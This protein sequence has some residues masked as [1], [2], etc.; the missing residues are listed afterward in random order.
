M[1]RGISVNVG[2]PG[3]GLGTL[4]YLLLALTMPLRY[5]ARVARRRA[6]PGEGWIVAR[7]TGLALGVLLAITAT[8]IAVG[9]VVIRL[10][11]DAVIRGPVAAIASRIG[12]ASPVQIST[13]LLT[14]L[15]LIVILGIIEVT[16]ALVARRR[17]A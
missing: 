15:L 13:V 1:K 10:R 12:A 16:G 14:G 5:L 7:Q 17:P 3:S 8:G 6:A 11:G 4:L 2:L 9:V